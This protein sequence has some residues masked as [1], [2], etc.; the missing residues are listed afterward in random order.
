MS[1]FGATLSLFG[2]GLQ[3]WAIDAGLGATLVLVGALAADRVLARRV[4][5]GAR[6][7]LF[8]AVLIRAALPA[9]FMSVLGFAWLGP[10]PTP[11]AAFVGE[12]EVLVASSAAAATTGLGA[13]A[14]IAVGYLLVAVALGLA[15]G[16]ARRR[17]SGAMADTRPVPPSLVGASVSHAPSAPLRAH[18]SLG[19]VVVGLWRPVIVIPE[20]LLAS[21]QAPALVAVLAHERAHV[22]RRDPLLHAVVQVACIVA[23]PL[24]PV[25]IAARQMRQLCEMAC[26]ERALAGRDLD[27]RRRYGELLVDMADGQTRVAA[28]AL[29]P[30]FGSELRARIHALRWRHRW[31]VLAQALMIVGLGGGLVA[32]SGTATEAPPLKDTEATASGSTA[33]SSHRR[34]NRTDPILT[35]TKEGKLYLLGRPVEATDLEREI[36]AALRE[37]ASVTVLLRGDQDALLGR[38]VNLMA[39]AKR[40]GARNIAVLTTPDAGAHVIPGQATVRGSLDKDVI[41]RT[42]RGH[43]HEVKSCYETELARDPRLGGR[44]MVQ[45]TIAATG[46]VVESVVQSST[47]NNPSVESCIVTAVRTWEFPKPLGGGIV[48]VSYPFVLTAT[49]GVDATPKLPI[50]ASPSAPA[51]PMSSTNEGPPREK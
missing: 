44:V 27:G 46:A 9:G 13:D 40:A 11:P 2:R 32:C 29:A 17:L 30:S 51:P 31:P 49:G 33:A 16:L 19:P 18:A 12:G 35:V 15:W 8:A 43:L 39:T 1:D 24:L 26:D 45:F 47:L 7:W 14:W 28:H 23:W 50:A 48:N 36:A 6:L 21:E 41:R 4:G 37:A 3:T 10:S 5:A 34:Q 22:A 38:A 20:V 25:W 42:I